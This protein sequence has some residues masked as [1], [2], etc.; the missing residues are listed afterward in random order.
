MNEKVSDLLTSPVS[1]AS[2]L[3]GECG[4][5]RGEQV[6]NDTFL[7]NIIFIKIMQLYK[8]LVLQGEFGK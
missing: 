8:C 7:L 4:T 6:Q 3:G 2:Q 5:T 1:R